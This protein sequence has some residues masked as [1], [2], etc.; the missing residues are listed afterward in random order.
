MEQPLIFGP[1][2]LTKYAF[3]ILYL[4]MR[5]YLNQERTR[6]VDGKEIPHQLGHRH[7]RRRII[8]ARFAVRHVKVGDL[9]AQR[10]PYKRLS[11]GGQ[12]CMDQ[13]GTPKNDGGWRA[14]PPNC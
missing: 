11:H 9:Q 6:Q 7:V 1:S 4:L 12:R 10:F 8:L 5:E 13:T 2:L 14:V 3:Q